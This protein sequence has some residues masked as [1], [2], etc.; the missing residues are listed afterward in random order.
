MGHIV[1]KT[2][3]D[4]GVLEIGSFNFA[5]DP[6]GTEK[7][8]NKLNFDKLFKNPTALRKV[9]RFLGS[10]AAL[11]EPQALIGI[12]E[13]GENLA[14]A[15]NLYSEITL[16]L[17]LL[18]K[19]EENSTHEHK[20]FTFRDFNDQDL[21]DSVKRVVIVEDVF[22]KFTNTRGVLEVED[23]LGKTVGVVAV[24]DR[25]IHPSRIPVPVPHEA[26]VQEYIPRHIGKGEALY[27]ENRNMAKGD[28]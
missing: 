18:D 11:Y 28:L 25:G 7:A 10:V 20:L 15:V 22:N 13:G 27:F 17:V 16:P 1:R 9:A 26:L 2:V 6:E 3:L 14:E 19:D 23:V 24:W 8:N 4:A 12:P 21:L 5:G